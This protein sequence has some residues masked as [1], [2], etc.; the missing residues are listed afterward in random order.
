MEPSHADSGE[1]RVHDASSY[2]RSAPRPAGNDYLCVLLLAR[3]S[4]FAP[5]KNVFSR[6]ERR[7]WGVLQAAP[8]E[9]LCGGR[10]LARLR[11]AALLGGLFVV[12]AFAQLLLHT[13]PFQ[14][15]FKAAQGAADG[16]AVMN[17]HTQRHGTSSGRWW[18]QPQRQRKPR[19]TRITRMGEQHSAE[20]RRF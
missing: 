6:S 11:A 1:V 19:M 15:F 18:T 17:A 8:R 12:T 2:H 14:E 10:H 5:R 20:V 4:S 3:E 7:Q 16:F 9:R 13:G